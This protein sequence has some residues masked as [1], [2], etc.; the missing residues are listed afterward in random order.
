MK[1]RPWIQGDRNQKALLNAFFDALK[2]ERSLVFVYAK[3]TPLKDDEQWIIVGVGRITSKGRLEEWNYDPADHKG[4]RSY[5]WERSV[6]HGIRPDGADGVLLPYHDLFRRCEAD[7]NFDPTEFMAFAPTEY[8][9]EFSYASEHVSSATPIAALLAVKAALAN[10]AE[11]FGG[12]W[13]RQLKWID[14]LYG[15]LV[16]LRGLIRGLAPSSVQWEPTMDINS[17]TTAGKGPAKTAI[18]GRC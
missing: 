15:E 4:L 9:Q 12:D 6:C 3:R 17:P 10:Y 18:R 13:S 5:L 7:E 11:R 1:E 2:P 8:R 16:T 14:Q